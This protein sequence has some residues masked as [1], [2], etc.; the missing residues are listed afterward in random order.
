MRVWTYGELAM[1]VLFSRNSRL[2][3]MD[4][5]KVAVVKVF[6]TQYTCTYMLY[7]EY[8]NCFTDQIPN[9]L[10]LS[11]KAL[12][13]W[14]CALHGT[15]WVSICNWPAYTLTLW[16][17]KH[18]NVHWIA[19]TTAVLV[20][21]HWLSTWWDACTVHLSYCDCHQ[22]RMANKQSVHSVY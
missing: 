5:C 21:T 15:Q 17:A 14:S 9:S 3:L 7:N 19:T 6:N 11:C 10:Q 13:L 22:W 20:H 2:P 8:S 4:H 18:Q 12:L 16:E 1:I